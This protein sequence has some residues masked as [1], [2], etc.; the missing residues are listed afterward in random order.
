[1]C[2]FKQ[3]S[4]NTESTEVCFVT[5]YKLK[6]L[7]ILSKH[8]QPLYEVPLALSLVTTPLA[9]GPGWSAKWDELAEGWFTFPW[10][11]KTNLYSSCKIYATNFKERQYK[12]YSYYIL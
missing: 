6:L 11:G 5:E 8:N 2:I 12:S 9:L 3:D 4:N 7:R 10:E 1:M